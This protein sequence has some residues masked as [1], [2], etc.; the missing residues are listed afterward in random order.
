VVVTVGTHNHG[1]LYVNGKS[2]ASFV[3]AIRPVHNARFT[4]GADYDKTWRGRKVTSY[5]HGEIDEVA[6]YDHAI[7][8]RRVAIE[9]AA[10]R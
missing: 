1:H 7:T 3:S 4:I 10:G 2:E 9:W 6:I 5:W 8:A